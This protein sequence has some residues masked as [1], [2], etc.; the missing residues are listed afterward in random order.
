MFYTGQL[1]LNKPDSA[2]PV[3]LL[4]GDM[5]INGIIGEGMEELQLILNASAKAH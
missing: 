1:R 5:S 4:E 2:G 3:G